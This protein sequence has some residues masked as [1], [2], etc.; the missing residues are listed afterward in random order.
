ML[1]LHPLY[2]YTCTLLAKTWC[3]FQTFIATQPFT[4]F[5]FALCFILDL[6][7]SRSIVGLS[8]SLARFCL[9][10][11][12]PP[13][14]FH[15][16]IS[17]FIYL[18]IFGPVRISTFTTTPSP[19]IQNKSPVCIRTCIIVYTATCSNA[20]VKLLSHRCSIADCKWVQN[21]ST[22]SVSNHDHHKTESHS[23]HII[24]VSLSVSRPLYNGHYWVLL[25]RLKPCYDALLSV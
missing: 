21:S 14:D 15:L 4:V 25:E 3:T 6:F 22:Q 12:I 20:R 7:K 13:S 23:Y 10:I 5:Q 19:S 9:G 11:S 8:L 17:L 24:S 2:I 1:P 18:V 16:F